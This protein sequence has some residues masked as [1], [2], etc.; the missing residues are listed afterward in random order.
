MWTIWAGIASI[1]AGL[2]VVLGAFAAHGLKKVLNPEMLAIFETGVR[3]QMYHALGLLAVSA[4]MTRID[5]PGLKIAAFAFVFGTVLFS[6]SLYGLAMSGPRW[7]GPVTPIG[8]LSYVVGWLAFALAMF[9][10]S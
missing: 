2:G 9:R 5:H 4:A 10:P 1:L 3:Y 8:G 7:L 6:G